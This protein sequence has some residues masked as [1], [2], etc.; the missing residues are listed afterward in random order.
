[1]KYKYKFYKIL[2]VFAVAFLSVLFYFQNVVISGKADNIASTTEITYSDVLDDLKKDETFDTGKY[3]VDENDYTLRIIQIAESTAKELYVYVYR[4]CEAT[5]DLL[6]TSINL[7]IPK[8][9]ETIKS[10]QNLNNFL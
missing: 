5:K 10:P 2:C 4:P 1:M 3:P 8:I 9:N 7:S 6:A